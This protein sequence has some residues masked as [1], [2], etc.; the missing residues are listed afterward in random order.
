MELPHPINLHYPASPLKLYMHLYPNHTSKSSREIYSLEIRHPSHL[1][2]CNIHQES[3]NLFCCLEIIIPLGK[4]CGIDYTIFIF[5]R[6]VDI[7]FTHL[8]YNPEFF[9]SHYYPTFL[10]GPIHCNICVY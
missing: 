2:L 8:L 9:Y 6:S 5:D 4:I 10:Y 7:Q 3:Y 1:D